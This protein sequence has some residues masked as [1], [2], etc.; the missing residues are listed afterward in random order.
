MMNGRLGNEA[1]VFLCGTTAGHLRSC[2][3][4]GQ[5]AL[6][7]LK[8]RLAILRIGQ[9]RSHTTASLGDY[10]QSEI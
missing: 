2:A 4:S 10:R 9:A 1:P 6:L 5:V 8:Q 3:T 7:L